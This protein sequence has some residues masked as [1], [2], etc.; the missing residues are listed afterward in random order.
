MIRS[1]LS[2]KGKLTYQAGAGIVIG[3]EPQGE[4]NEVN[5]KISALRRAIEIAEISF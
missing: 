1:F 3:S 5:S 4:L 2:T